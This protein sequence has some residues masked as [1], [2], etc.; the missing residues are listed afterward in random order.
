LL[1]RRFLLTR[2]NTVKHISRPRSSR[3]T[4]STTGMWV[5]LVTESCFRWPVSGITSRKG[6]RI[7]LRFA[8]R[9]TKPIH[10]APPIQPSDLRLLTMALGSHY[11]SKARIRDYWQLFLVLTLI[12]GGISSVVKAYEYNGEVGSH[13]VRVLISMRREETQQP[14][15]DAGHTPLFFSLYSGY[16]PARDQHAVGSGFCWF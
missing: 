12:L 13:E 1:A 4:H 16:R 2:E 10:M 9:A 11:A 8:W 14:C 6:R 7:R 15:V 3:R 5:F